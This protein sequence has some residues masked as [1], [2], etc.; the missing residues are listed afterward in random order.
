MVGASYNSD[1]HDVFPFHSTLA[2]LPPTEAAFSERFLISQ[3]ADVLF[4]A[5]VL[6]HVMSKLK[7]IIYRFIVPKKGLDGRL[8]RDLGMNNK[9]C[10]LVER[11]RFVSVGK[12]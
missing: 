8:P 11:E 6:T 7:Q 2:A 1:I 4:L 3:H 10:R 5:V 12:E 9:A